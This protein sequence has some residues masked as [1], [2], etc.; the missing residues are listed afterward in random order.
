VAGGVHRGRRPR[1]HRADPAAG[2]RAARRFGQVL[3]IGC[4]EGQVARLAV[5][6]GRHAGS[7]ASTPR[8]PRSRSPPNGRGSL[9]TPAPGPT[10]C[11]SPT[12]AFDAPSPAWCSSTSRRSTRPS[13]RS[14]GCST[15]VGGSC[16]SST[17]RCCR[18]P[19]AAGSTTR[20]STR[21]SSTGGSGP[22]STRTHHRGGREGRVHPLHPPSPQPLRQRLPP[23]GCSIVRMDEPAPPPGFLAQAPSTR[24]RHHPPTSRCA[25]HPRVGEAPERGPG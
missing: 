6:G 23:T 19:V 5:A 22:T 2:R 9:A 17:T 3:D 1:V 21:P 15:R 25:R 4:G 13:P 14:P 10:D 20:S 24:R 18:P 12:P 11:P 16:S 7:W 8:G